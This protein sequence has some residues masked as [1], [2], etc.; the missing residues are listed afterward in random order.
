MFYSCVRIVISSGAALFLSDR[1]MVYFPTKCARSVMNCMG[2]R[3]MRAPLDTPSTGTSADESPTAH[4]P[5]QTA[6]LSPMPG[7]PAGFSTTEPSSRANATATPRSL[8]DKIT[9]PVVDK[10]VCQ[11]HRLF[12]GPCHDSP[13]RNR[14]CQGRHI[15]VASILREDQISQG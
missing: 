9:Q 8:A 3:R 1:V 13:R 12:L 14:P 2:K 11:A 6:R 5:R 7:G 15:H 10:P 4:I